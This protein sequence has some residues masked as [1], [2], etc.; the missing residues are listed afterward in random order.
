MTSDVKA[1]YPDG[2]SLEG[3]LCMVKITNARP[4]SVEGE[5]ECLLNE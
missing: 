2:N 4:Y 3:R 5:M 1:S